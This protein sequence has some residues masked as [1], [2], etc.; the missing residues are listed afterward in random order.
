MVLKIKEFIQKYKELENLLADVSV[1]EDMDLYKKYLKERADLEPIFLK[2]EEYLKVLKETEENKELLNEGDED[3]KALAKAELTEL[4]EKQ[5]TLEDELNILM[6]PKDPLDEKNVILEIRSGVG[7]EEAAL[8]AADLLRMYTKY[9][10]RENFKIEILSESYTDLGG[11]KECVLL[12]SGDKVYSKLKFESGAHRVQ[13]VPE[14]ESSGRIH[15]S[16]CTVAVLPEADEVDI[17]IDPKDLKIDTF[18]ASGAG[19]QYVNKTESAIR[20]TH[21]PTGIV[22]ECQDEK[23]QLKNKEKAMKALRARVFDKFKTEQKN[24]QDSNR[25]SLVGSGD[26]S[27]RIRTY[28]FPQGRVTDHRINLTLYKLEDFL[29][30]DMTEIVQALILQERA[31]KAKEI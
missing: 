7:G 18:R 23:S 1:I 31:E 20:I 28:N 29:N 16:A 22:V 19:G 24:E 6:L 15:T 11:I 12:I 4:E 5:K 17:V 8:F 25:K 27:E 9:A 13:R 30:G 14:T 26:R 10:E 3:I 2:G 21:I